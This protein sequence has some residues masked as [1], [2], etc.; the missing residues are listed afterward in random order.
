MGRIV[1]AVV[2]VDGALLGTVGPFAVEA[3]W[4][5]EAASV[6][7]RLEDALGVAVFVLR[8]LRVEGGDGGRDGH[9]TY[10]AEALERPAGTWAPGA[11]DHAALVAPHAL[12]SPWARIDGLRELLGWASGALAAAGRPVT[13]APEQ[14][15]TWN[16]AGLFRLPTAYGPVW[17]KATPGFATDEAAVIT[18]F[19]Q[20]DPGLV[21][22]V[23]AAGERRV[24]LDHLPGEDCWDAAP[25][26][27]TSVIGRFV[28]AQAELASRRPPWLPDRRTPVITG[29]VLRLLDHVEGLTAGER[30]AARDLVG[31]WPELDR[32]GLPD[33]VV[34][35][36][37]HPG[38]WRC[39]GGPP[40]VVDFADAHYGNP[41]L[42]GLRAYDYLPE[43]KRPVA[44]RAWVDAWEARWPGADP[45]RALDVAAPLAHLA[46]AVR[47]Q[48]FLDGIEPAERV[49]HHD[50]PIGVIRA[51]L[52][53]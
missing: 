20:A 41:V 12:R 14:R 50:D 21:P 19:A 35:G 2:T 17:L 37:F 32:C 53:L 26:A 45:A 23:V 38:N 31:R 43:A 36:D 29:K 40:A 7:G 16:L 48:E 52:T 18:A 34:H 42:D 13:G 27:I 24:L 25:G 8:L 9:V 10:H 1:S 11:V 46:Y 15:R 3:P 4:W 28:A 22:A 6:V 49:Y 47:Y 44:A 5:S 39:D 51:A 33:T 30:A